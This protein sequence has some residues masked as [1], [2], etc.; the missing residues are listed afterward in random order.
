RPDH[1]DQH[2]PAPENDLRHQWRTGRRPAERRLHQKRTWTIRSAGDGSK[3][4]RTYV[5]AWIAT[6]SP[7]HYLLVRKRRTTGELAF[8]YCFVPENSPQN[9][10]M[11]PLTVA[12]IKRLFNA[13]TTYT[14]SLEH[15]AHWSAWRRRHQ[16]R[17]RWFHQQIRLA[18]AYKQLS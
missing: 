16:A 15:T 10:G 5:W 12:E 8:R 1:G 4:E 6:A 14:A 17:A 9:P 2:R 11:I 3:G 18:T 7:T 13:A